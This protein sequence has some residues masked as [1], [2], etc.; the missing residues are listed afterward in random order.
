[1]ST[2][3]QIRDGLH[4]AWDNVTEGWQHL[5][6]RASHAMT[7]FQPVRSRGDVQTVEDQLITG[8]ARWGVLAAELHE[9]DGEVVVRLEVPGMEREDFDI[10]VVDGRYLVVGGEKQVERE[11]THGR[12]YVMERAYGRFERAIPL[13][14]EVTEEGT[15][16]RYRRGVLRVTIPK[17]RKAAARRIEVQD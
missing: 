4:R 10:G 3:D 17:T 7:R 9:T 11:D 5:R 14:A 2:L 13:P 12:F 15:R 8:G 1:M 6:D 16:A